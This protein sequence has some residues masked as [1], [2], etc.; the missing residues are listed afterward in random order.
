[1]KRRPPL[2]A[3]LAEAL[4]T[5]VPAAFREIQAQGSGFSPRSLYRRLRRAIR[6]LD[7]RVARAG[8]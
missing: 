7:A 8:K 2:S 1:V 4:E 5:R 3:R 6:Y